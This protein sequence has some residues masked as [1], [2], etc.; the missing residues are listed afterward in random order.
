MPD[1][2]QVFSHLLA[3]VADLLRRA[4]TLDQLLE[5]AIQ[6]CPAHLM[7]FVGKPAVAGIP[8]GDHVTLVVLAEHLL[9]HTLGAPADP[10]QHGKRRHQD[11]EVQRLALLPPAGLVHVGHR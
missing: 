10:E 9:R 3:G 1:R 11:P 2:E 4:A 5:V 7:A 8:V 6:V